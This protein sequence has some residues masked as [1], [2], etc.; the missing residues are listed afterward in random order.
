MLDDFGAKTFTNVPPEKLLL[1]CLEK[2]LQIKL[3]CSVTALPGTC[4][5]FE[6][7]ECINLHEGA[8]TKMPHFPVMNKIM[9]RVENG[10]SK[11]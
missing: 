8:S 2:M 3:L 1:L 6:Q 4:F 5:L 10:A 9:E 11:P 7:R